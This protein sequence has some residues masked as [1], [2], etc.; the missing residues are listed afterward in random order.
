MLQE[1]LACVQ[2][3][4]NT[5]MVDLETEERIKN[6]LEDEVV[7]LFDA[8]TA[9]TLEKAELEVQVKELNADFFDLGDLL[10]QA[11][12]ENKEKQPEQKL[13]DAVTGLDD[14][15]QKQYE[16][17]I[18][19]LEALIFELG[20][21]L[22]KQKAA[23]KKALTEMKKEAYDNG[24]A[25]EKLKKENKDLKVAITKFKEEAFEED[26]KQITE[27][28]EGSEEQTPKKQSSTT[29]ET[30]PKPMVK[31]AGKNLMLD[32]KN[33]LRNKGYEVQD[34]GKS[35]QAKKPGNRHIEVKPAELPGSFKYIICG[36]TCYEFDQAIKASTYGAKAIA[37]KL[38][39]EAIS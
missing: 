34:T 1:E 16:D 5:T 2:A 23:E 14:F 31:P 15:L 39:A 10:M 3:D 17:R 38:D 33:K 26:R 18:D 7:Q 9:Y 13:E 28:I 21:D 30:K 24:M 8:N 4:L 6:A 36:Q 25:M 12:K 37:P 29:G 27:E 32:I 22:D 19:H 35:L 20:D 11:I